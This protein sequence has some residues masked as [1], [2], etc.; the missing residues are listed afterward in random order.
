MK[1]GEISS[2]IQVSASHW[3]SRSGCRGIGAGAVAFEAHA[4]PESRLRYVLAFPGLPRG[5][6][7]L[8]VSRPFRH[9]W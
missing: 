3:S 2:R 7:W 1:F 8:D 4:N 6:T 5:F 9:A